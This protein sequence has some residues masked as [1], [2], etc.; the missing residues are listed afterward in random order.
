M[1]YAVMVEFDIKPEKIQRFKHRVAQQATD[2]LNKEEGCLV[3]EIWLSAD[4]PEQIYLYEIY[5]DKAAFDFHLDSPHFREFDQDVAGW[6]T[7]KKVG[8]WDEMLA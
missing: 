3:F 4:K 7:S 8:T 6:V 2:S 1:C 5:A